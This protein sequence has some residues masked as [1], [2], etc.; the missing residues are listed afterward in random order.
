VIGAAGILVRPES[1]FCARLHDFSLPPKTVAQTRW[2][3]CGV[4]TYTPPFGQ[5][6]IRRADSDLTS[7]TFWLVFGRTLLRYVRLMSSVCLSVVCLSSVTLLQ[8]LELFGNIFAPTDSS[9]IRTAFIKI[10][11]KHSKGFWGLM[12]VKYNGVWKIGVF[13]PI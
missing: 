12:Q 11:G 8:R 2:Y 13:R 10:L 4:R 6:R 9:G 1:G 5:S 7:V 3:K